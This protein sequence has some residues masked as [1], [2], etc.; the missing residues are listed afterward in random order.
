MDNGQL[1]F[2][3]S[4]YELPAMEGSEAEKA[5]DIGKL[6]GQSG[7]IT[8]DPG[9]G[10]TGS[11]KSAITFVDG[12]KGILRYR[13]YPIEQLAASSS[14]SE[15]AYLLI[16]GELPNADTLAQWRQDLA[17]H[18]VL[19]G[20]MARLFEHYP[21]SAHPMGVLS[22]LTASMSAYY[23]EPDDAEHTDLNI[24]RLLGQV[25]TIAAYAY[26]RSIGKPVVAAGGGPGL[27]REFPTPDVR[28]A[29][30]GLSGVRSDGPHDE[31]AFDSTR[32]S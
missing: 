28:H 2:D 24:R 11:C 1:H 4:D 9:Y 23:P 13:G 16:Y 22:A 6:R 32:G 19:D 31:Y 10:N 21:Q 5:L 26:K 8:Y 18:S 17:S 25:K 30:R 27:C 14:F 20:E 15:V 7:A 12:E 29:G 3:G